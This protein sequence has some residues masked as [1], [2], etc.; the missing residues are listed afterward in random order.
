MQCL[1]VGSPL[2][3]RIGVNTLT[4]DLQNA[5]HVWKNEVNK[6]EQKIATYLEVRD[7]VT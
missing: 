2:T 1:V 5:G 6:K 4:S 7:F 3:V